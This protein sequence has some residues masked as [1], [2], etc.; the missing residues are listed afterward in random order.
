[1]ARQGNYVSI[2]CGDNLPQYFG[3]THFQWYNVLGA[4]QQ[5][6]L[7]PNERLFVDDTGQ[8]LF[9]IVSSCVFIV[10]SYLYL[11]YLFSFDLGCR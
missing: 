4:E 1:M 5:V 2:R 9:V 3:P 10:S 7:V 6:P 11:C 8:G